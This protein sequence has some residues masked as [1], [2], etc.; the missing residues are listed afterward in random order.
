MGS[1]GYS[2]RRMWAS[3]RKHLS[4]KDVAAAGGWTDTA[5]LE[6]CYQH[7]DPH[8]LEEVVLSGRTLRMQRE[9]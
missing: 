8:T 2:F 4:V 5:T 7:A 1:E 6:R 3:K 9:G